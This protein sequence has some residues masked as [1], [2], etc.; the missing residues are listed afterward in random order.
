MDA[1]L[2]K[3]MNEKLKKDVRV[4]VKRNFGKR[5]EAFAVDC[6]TCMC[7]LAYDRLFNWDSEV[8]WE[9]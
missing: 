9:K 3:E 1:E 6:P 7:W 5:C 8:K 4:Y 2:E